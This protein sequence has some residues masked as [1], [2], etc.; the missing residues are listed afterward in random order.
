MIFDWTTALP[1]ATVFLAAGFCKGIVGIGL[2]IFA[3]SLLSHILGIR[4]AIYIT[5]IPAMLTSLAQAIAGPVLRESIQRLWPLLLAGGFAITI[6][7]Q[8][9]MKGDKRII[10]F[11]VGTMIMIYSIASLAKIRFPAPGRNEKYW[12]PIFGFLGG[13]V[14]GMSG[15]YAMPVVPYLQTLG[16]KRDEL[17]QSIAIWFVTGAFIMASVVGINGAYTPKLVVLTVIASITSLFGIWLGGMARGRIP[18]DV[19]VK[20]FLVAFL[21]L[22]AGIFYRAF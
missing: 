2:P 10:A 13:S 4:E 9:G 14:G 15:M 6:S 19:F 1:V 21:F 22:G 11:I 20:V 17:I 18:E 7:T 5:L 8:I 3:V 12:S 16:L